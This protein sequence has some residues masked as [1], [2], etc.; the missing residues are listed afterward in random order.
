MPRNNQQGSRKV[1][2]SLLPHNSDAER[3]VLGSALLSRNAA[4]NVLSSLN[5][6]DFFE[7]KHRIIF[8]AMM[9]LFEKKVPIDSLTVTEELINIKELEN[10]GGVEYLKVCSDSMVALSNLEFYINIVNDQSVLRKMLTT[11]RNIDEAYMSRDIDNVNDFIIKAESDF[12]E[13]IE[14]RKISGFKTTGDVA[15]IVKNE[16]D[17]MV[18]QAKN[19][20]NKDIIGLTTGYPRLNKLT[21]GFQPEQMIII[22]GR[23]GLGKT[24][25][26]L[27]FAYKASRFH[28]VPVAIFSLEMS[29]DLLVRRLIACEACVDLTKISTGQLSDSERMK[30][31]SAISTVANTKIFIDDSPGLKLTDI[32]AK[33]KKLQAAN[34]DLGMVIIDYLGLIQLTSKGKGADSR[35]E[36][37]RKIT[38]ALKDLSRELKVPVIV[39]SQLSRDVEKRDSKRPMLSDLRDSGSIEQDADIVMLLY[40]EDYYDK[41]S[42]KGQNLAG[43]NKTP[44]NM[45]GD[46]RL[47]MSQAQKTEAQLADIPASASYVE[48][49]VAKNRNGQTGKAALFFYKAYGRFDKPSQEWEDSMNAITAETFD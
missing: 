31:A 20:E 5:E 11:I 34:P 39:L 1:A 2:S 48:V 43:G 41:T 27:N 40:R 29:S 37:V 15:K 7:G 36:E 16:I 42:K 24:A 13:S 23:P 12:K 33:A 6:D 8:R 49:N 47:Q 4:L 28:D 25:L 30:V 35:Q 26:A 46:E 18:A 17:E 44:A 3:A 22:A 10:V 9:N 38:L 14:R 45:S 21:Q 32:V 19:S